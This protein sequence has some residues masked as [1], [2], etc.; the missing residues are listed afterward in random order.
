MPSQLR[1]CATTQGQQVFRTQS[2]PV[3]SSALPWPSLGRRASGPRHPSRRARRSTP[4]LLPLR[5]PPAH[6]AT[7][8]LPSPPATPASA[9]PCCARSGRQDRQ[10]QR[11]LSQAAGGGSEKSRGLRGSCG[12]SLPPTAARLRPI[13][14]PANPQPFLRSD[15][16]HSSPPSGP[17]DQMSRQKESKPESLVL[18]PPPGGFKAASAFPKEA[19][20]SVHVSITR[21]GH[22][23]ARGAPDVSPTAVTVSVPHCEHPQYGTC[24]HPSS[25]KQ[26][27]EC[28]Q[29]TFRTPLDQPRDFGKMAHFSRPPTSGGKRR[30]N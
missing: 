16:A 1:S 28:F 14:I 18:G 21:A 4:A 19:G 13:S 20:M 7:P 9:S 2:V 30:V 27:G 25:P 8:P 6:A 15:S 5:A 22:W 3:G 26:R 17:S 29:D 24:I 23:V 11:R 10:E 12:F